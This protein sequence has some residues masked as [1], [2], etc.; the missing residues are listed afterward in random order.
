MLNIVIA[1]QAEDVSWIDDL[2]DHCAVYLYNRGAALPAGAFTREVRQTTLRN[3][4]GN[5][6]AFLYHLMH[7]ADP[8]QADFTVFTSGDP[9]AHAPAWFELLLQPQR[10][11]D[12]QPLSVLADEHRAIPP[13]H[14]I[15][16]DNRDWIG[17][18]AIRTERYSLTSLA[19][20]GFHDAQA[21][22]IAETYRLAHDLQD[23]THL[24]AHFLTLCGLD[25][26]AEQAR[27]ADIGVFAYGP[28][29]A[30]RNTR[31]ADFLTEARPHLGRLDVLSRS[32]PIYQP[33][34]ERA[35][36]HFFGA[37]FVRFEPVRQA[38][39]SVTPIATL[40][41]RMRASVDAVLTK[42]MPITLRRREPTPAVPLPE[43]EQLRSQ[44]HQALSAGHPE[45]A[46]Q[47]L[48]KALLKEP[49]HLDLLAEVAE[50]SFQFGDFYGAEAH[51][52]RALTL[53]PEHA[54]CQF[55]LAMALAANGENQ[56]ALVMFD[57]LMYSNTNRSFREC[58]PDLLNEA[59]KEAERLHA[60]LSEELHR[61]AA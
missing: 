5:T 43:V 28:V 17:S 1:R 32:A 60:E 48:R 21:Q 27:Q 41:R 23:G 45:Q 39:T 9:F 47:L 29:F 50:L 13:R 15:E 53:E 8:R 4:G 34:F 51:A 59:L 42:G 61:A 36:L 49:R 25:Q 40:M 33:L 6:S 57:T 14:L 2:P 10:W 19:P 16:H 54:G 20:T 30:V 22:R 55:T 11:S 31:L 35:W 58:H 52:R 38:Q 37:P 46:Q 26:L 18:A 24:I 44:A 56:E 7:D 3:V 12:V